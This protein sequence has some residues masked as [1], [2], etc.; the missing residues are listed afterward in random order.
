MSERQAESRLRSSLSQRERRVLMMRY[1]DKLSA[2]EIG[3]VLDLPASDVES[4]LLRLR[5]RALSYLTIE[6]LNLGDA[7]ASVP[8]GERP[9]GG[10]L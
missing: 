6:S 7:A 3:L 5:H 9:D 1:C 2:E 10:E 4:M 8:G